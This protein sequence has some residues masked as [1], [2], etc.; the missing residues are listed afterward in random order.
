MGKDDKNTWQEAEVGQNA[1]HLFCLMLQV[2]FLEQLMVV[3]D[4]VT[5]LSRKRLT[6]CLSL[7]LSLCLYLPLGFSLI[8]ATVVRFLTVCS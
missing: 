8:E 7:Y 2:P 6:W 4:V 5:I 3:D 1:L